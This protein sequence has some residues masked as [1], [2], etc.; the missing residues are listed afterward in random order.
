MS[1]SDIRRNNDEIEMVKVPY[2][3]YREL[4]DCVTIENMRMQ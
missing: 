1:P 3:A 2:E 4:L